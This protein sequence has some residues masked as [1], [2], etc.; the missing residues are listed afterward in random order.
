MDILADT[1]VWIDFFNKKTHSPEA[2]VLQ[3][4]L[5]SPWDN[6]WLCPV[7]YQELLQGFRDDNIFKEA[8]NILLNFSMPDLDILTVSDYAVDLYRHLRKKGA[9]IR[10]SAD[11]LIA[12]YAILAD[13]ALLYKDRDFSQIA[14]HCPLKICRL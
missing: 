1:S 11:C 12:A 7:I 2:A 3:K 8:K 6:I 4:F 5:Q 13:L 14:K 10:K 9:T